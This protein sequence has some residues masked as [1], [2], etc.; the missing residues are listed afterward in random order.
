MC[1]SFKVS[2]DANNPMSLQEINVVCK[3]LLQPRSKKGK[4]L[5]Y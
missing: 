5:Y 1:T 3:W 2:T 4:Y